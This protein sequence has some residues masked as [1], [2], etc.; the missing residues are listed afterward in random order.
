MT[1]FNVAKSPL[2]ALQII[3]SFTEIPTRI[4]VFDR[5]RVSGATD[6]EAMYKSTR[7]D[8][9]FLCPGKI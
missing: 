2:H 8:Y 4:G 6:I 7:Y 1:A 9:R 3:S 5:A